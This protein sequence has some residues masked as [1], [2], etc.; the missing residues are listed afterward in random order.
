MKISD[1]TLLK[2]MHRTADKMMADPSYTG[3][4]RFARFSTNEKV[5]DALRNQKLY[6]RY[7]RER[8]E[9]HG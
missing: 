2:L 6:A 3:T 9:K 7:K 5:W 1:E 8:G 4:R